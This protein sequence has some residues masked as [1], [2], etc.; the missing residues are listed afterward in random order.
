[1][2]DAARLFAEAQAARL[3][4]DFLLLERTSRDLI[5]A[6]ERDG[7]D[8]ARADGYYHLGLA[9][10]NLNRTTEATVATAF[11]LL[12]E[13]DNPRWVAWY[14]DVWF[15]IAARLGRYDLAAVVLG[16]TDKCRDEHNQPRTQAIM[17]WFSEARE[18]LVRELGIERI[19]ELV[20]S[21]EAL[22]V[23]SA[24]ALAIEMRPR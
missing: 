20:E 1:M 7:N 21:G 15:L 14:F 3:A 22:T 9:L 2:D 4:S 8:K 12:G 23:E 5:A 24:Y 19:D 13:I 11:P 10:T 17:P 16:F 18:R 6:G